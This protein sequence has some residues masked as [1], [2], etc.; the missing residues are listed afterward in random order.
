MK[1]E[2]LTDEE[3]IYL[4]ENL[5]DVIELFKDAH[6]ELR[7]ELKSKCTRTRNKLERSDFTY[8]L[9]KEPIT[10]YTYGYCF[11]FARITKTIFPHSEF[12][13]NEVNDYLKHVFLKLDSNVFDIEYNDKKSETTLM[14]RDANE[15]DLKY[16]TKWFGHMDIDMYEKLK[17]K[18]Y[19]NI[20]SYL[21]DKQISSCKKLNK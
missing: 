10:C 1:K 20:K 19:R 7:L 5:N 14:Y 9:F 17:Y 8:L 12:V 6:E 15:K 4:E 21:A 3:R 16:I 2:F 18:F 13:V 11:Y